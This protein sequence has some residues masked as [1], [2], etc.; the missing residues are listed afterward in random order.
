MI[1][2]FWALSNEI[3]TMSL[4]DKETGHLTERIITMKHAIFQDIQHLGE[5]KIS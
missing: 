2:S 5:E 3:W 1:N 4:N